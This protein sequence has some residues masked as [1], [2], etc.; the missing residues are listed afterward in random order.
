MPLHYLIHRDDWRK[1]LP[2]NIIH[3]NQY[4]FDDPVSC[5]IWLIGS[6]GF[7]RSEVF[8]EKV[9]G[10]I[11]CSVGED[12]RRQRK[13]WPSFERWLTEEVTRMCDFFDEHGNQLVEKEDMLPGTLN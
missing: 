1:S 2:Y 7:D 3:Q 8:V 5:P 4:F 12:L 6:Y 9:T 11:Y 13:V 10:L